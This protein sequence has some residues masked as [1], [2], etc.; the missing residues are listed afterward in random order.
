MALEKR[1]S[2]AV[3]FIRAFI[4]KPTIQK[5]TVFVRRNLTSTVPHQKLNRLGDWP[6]ALGWQQ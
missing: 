4:I 1:E 5:S 3:F 2:M 6:K